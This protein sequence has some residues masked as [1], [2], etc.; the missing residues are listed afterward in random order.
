MGTIRGA[1][2][3]DS[4]FSSDDFDANNRTMGVS[5]KKNS[6]IR[7]EMEPHM[8]APFKTEYDEDKPWVPKGTKH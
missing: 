1:G 3:G 8:R 6:T 7:R 2:L 4:T 5:S